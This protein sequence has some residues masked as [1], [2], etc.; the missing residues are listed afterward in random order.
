MAGTELEYKIASIGYELMTRVVPDTLA[1]KYIL[2]CFSYF[3]YMTIYL[4]LI[5]DKPLV[6]LYRLVRR[7][8]VAY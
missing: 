2:V 8:S 6:R 7:S 3:L 4:F 5:F 1:Y